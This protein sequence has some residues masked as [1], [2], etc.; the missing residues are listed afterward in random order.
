MDKNIVK[1]ARIVRH[2]SKFEIL[3]RFG[4]I[5][6]GVLHG[7][8]GLAV[9]SLV[10]GV[11]EEV[12][13]SGVLAP[14]TRTAYGTILLLLISAGLVVLGIS[15]FVRVILMRKNPGADRKWPRQIGESAKGLA[16][17]VVGVSSM[18]FIF[19]KANEPNSVNSS[20]DFTAHLL[21]LP[22]GEALLL[23][24]GLGI[25][26]LGINFIYRGV[27]RRFVGVLDFAKIKLKR[28]VIIL[29]VIGYIAKGLTFISLGSLFCNA[30]VTLNP[31]KA[32]GLDGAFKNLIALPFGAQLLL[33]LGL[34]LIVYAIY[35]VARGMYAKL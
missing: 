18:A 29:G 31:S 13:Q 8:I 26:A 10:R 6:N 3:T 19:A 34:G 5:S 16:Y 4:Y 32:S 35:C 7:L 21:A 2:N 15:H 9:L 25:I 20:I 28:P 11:A 12:D 30:A 24:I 14:L 1:I 27:S 23:I 17:L 22:M 33:L